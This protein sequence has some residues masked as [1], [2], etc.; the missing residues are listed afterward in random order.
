MLPHGSGAVAF[1]VVVRALLGGEGEAA[2]RAEKGRGGMHGGDE[3]LID[4]ES[5]AMG[6]KETWGW[7]T[8]MDAANSGVPRVR[9]TFSDYF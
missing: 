3:A 4:L 2:E 1:I 9:A 8:E 6:G 5:K 7:L